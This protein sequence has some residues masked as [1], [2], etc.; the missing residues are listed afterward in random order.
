MKTTWLDERIR[1]GEVPESSRDEA[2]ARS[3]T[4]EGARAAG[5]LAA[6]DAEI[7]RRLPPGRMAERVEA[8]SRARH[9]SRRRV[10]GTSSWIPL[11]VA[12]CALLVAFLAVPS[13]QDAP[14]PAQHAAAPNPTDSPTTT[15]LPSREHAH[16]TST[17]VAVAEVL[18]DGIRVRGDGNLSILLVA[19]TGVAAPSSGPV[20]GGSTL[21][22]VAPHLVQGAVFSI[23]ETGT[24]Q[25]HW[26]LEGDSSR[27]VPA[28]PLP[29]DWETDPSNGWDRFVVVSSPTPFALRTVEAHLRGL[30]ASD[31]PR[32]RALSLPG[33][34]RAEAVLV[35][36]KAP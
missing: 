6:S 35:E 12:A 25:R 19:P 17:Q 26:P 24:I 34:L 1:L 18:D 21:R 20:V 11:A 22:I 10:W 27:T 32:H 30:L 15:T 3:A 7:L 2:L 36:R 29:R 5:D 28:G 4:A 33:N 16:G 31:D 14:A 9:D 23:D 8:R 13:T